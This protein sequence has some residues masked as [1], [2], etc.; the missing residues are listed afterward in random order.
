LQTYVVLGE[1]LTLGEQIVLG[2]DRTTPAPVPDVW[3]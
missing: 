1:V 3:R 2:E